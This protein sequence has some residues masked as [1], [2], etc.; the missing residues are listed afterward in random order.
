MKITVEPV[1]SNVSV[2][3]FSRIERDNSTNRL[4]VEIESVD[5]VRP[6]NSVK[7]DGT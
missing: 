5:T 1:S 4:M 2:P 7:N 6:I 3:R